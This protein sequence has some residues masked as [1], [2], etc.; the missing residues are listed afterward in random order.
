[1]VIYLEVQDSWY[2]ELELTYTSELFALLSVYE[3]DE[4]ERCLCSA[5]PSG[6]P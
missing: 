5:I 3:R 1:M 2:T 6:V 4:E